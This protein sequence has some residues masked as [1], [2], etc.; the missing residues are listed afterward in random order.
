MSYNK[1]CALLNSLIG[2]VPHKM[3]KY[4]QKCKHPGEIKH[5]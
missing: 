4:L 2:L 5:M 1:K 3:A